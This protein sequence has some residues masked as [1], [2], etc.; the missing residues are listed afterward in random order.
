[1]KKS[2]VIFLRV[3][4]ILTVILGAA[5]FSLR[6][7]FLHESQQAIVAATNV[8][9][10]PVVGDSSAPLS[11][12]EFF[13]Y[14]CEHC[15]PMSR[16]VG[17]VVQGDTQ[18]K[19]ILRPVVF[20]GEESLQISAFVLAADKQKS[21]ASAAIHHDIMN[22]ST[23]P[24]FA[25]VAKIAASQGIDVA[26][27]QKDAESPAIQSELRANTGWVEDIGFYRVPSLI[28]GGKGYVPDAGLPSVN[29]LK[30]MIIDAKEKLE[31]NPHD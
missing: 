26:R 3:I 16:L 6:A 2:L 10:A 21:G 15:A 4:F 31:K 14:R 25:T 17:E 19:I 1:M 9:A 11:I 12:V 23:L 22:L 5:F 20:N 27:A 29:E 30:L 13:D 18:I 7:Y 8:G 28:I 24:D